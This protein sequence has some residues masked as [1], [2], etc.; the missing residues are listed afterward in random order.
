[1]RTTDS[2]DH[3]PLRPE[4]VNRSFFRTLIEIQETSSVNKKWRKAL[5]YPSIQTGSQKMAAA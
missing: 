5:L 4:V 3:L 1:M 2:T